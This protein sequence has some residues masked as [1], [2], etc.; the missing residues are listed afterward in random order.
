MKDKYCYF[1]E[2]QNYIYYL[3]DDEDVSY[4]T[5]IHIIFDKDK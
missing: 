4:E 1:S 5:R 3:Y 2:K